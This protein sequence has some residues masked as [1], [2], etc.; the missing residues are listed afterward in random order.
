MQDVSKYNEEG[1]GYK[2]KKCSKCGGINYNASGNCV[3]C[4]KKRGRAYYEKNKQKVKLAAKDWKLRNKEKVKAG[5]KVYREREREKMHELQKAWAEKNKDKIKER[6][7]RFYIKHSDR[8]KEK[9][10]KWR[11]LNPDKVKSALQAYRAKPEYKEINIRNVAKR[12]SR[13]LGSSGKLSD[14]IIK[15]LLVSQKNKCVCCK[16]NLSKVE[17]HLDHIMPLSLGG[18]NVDNNVQ[19]LCKSCNLSKHAKHPIDFMQ[20]RGYLL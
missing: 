10:K 7:R 12:R 9:S 2:M 11:A 17:Y 16:T 18:E 13:I 8:L 5:A 20:E 19:I 1:W 14:G 6:T 15:K 3:G 4:Q